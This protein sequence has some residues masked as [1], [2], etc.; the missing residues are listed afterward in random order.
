MGGDDVLDGLFGEDADNESNTGK[1][2][3]KDAYGGGGQAGDEE[4]GFSPRKRQRIKQIHSEATQDSQPQT[5]MSQASGWEDRSTYEQSQPTLDLDVNNED[6]NPTSNLDQPI[7]LQDER[8]MMEVEVEG[9]MV[10]S[11][12]VDADGER[13]E[14]EETVGLSKEERKRRKKDR[15]KEEKR[16]KEGERKAK[17]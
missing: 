12:F 1:R 14:A 3:R 16:K 8:E 11:R 9:E 2:K 17:K 4:A 15:R 5:P 13:G 6:R 7:T 10:D